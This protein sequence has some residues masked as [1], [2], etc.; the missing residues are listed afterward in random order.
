MAGRTP[1]KPNSKLEG[2]LQ[3]KLPALPK[4]PHGAVILSEEMFEAIVRMVRLGYPPTKAF[5][6]VGIP[7]A[8]GN[9]WIATAREERRQGIAPE[10]TP[11]PNWHRLL[12]AIENAKA[13]L[14]GDLVDR[15]QEVFESNRGDARVGALLLEFLSRLDPENFG[16]KSALQ[17]EGKVEHLHGHVHIDGRHLNDADVQYHLRA[18][19]DIVAGI[20]REAHNARAQIE[21]GAQYV[22]FD[23]RD[24]PDGQF[25]SEAR[26]RRLAEGACEVVEVEVEEVDNDA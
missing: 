9:R 22:D 3:G 5:L 11:H 20:N 6:L 12:D 19:F 10:D 23:V 7:E 13:V 1:K 14:T 4:G 21:G 2:E 24:Y 17:V 25:S 8:T 15:L 18:A 26:R 16:R